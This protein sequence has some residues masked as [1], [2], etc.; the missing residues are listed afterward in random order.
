MTTDTMISLAQIESA[1]DRLER[2]AVKHTDA[3]TVWT[4]YAV[5]DDIIDILTGAWRGDEQDDSPAALQFDDDYPDRPI[6]WSDV[7]TDPR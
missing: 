2:L 5:K 3:D 1:F 6:Q 4:I 7:F